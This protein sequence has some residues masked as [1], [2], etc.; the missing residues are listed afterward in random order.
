M[1]RSPTVENTSRVRNEQTNSDIQCS[2]CKV[3][4]N[5][6]LAFTSNK[7]DTL[8]E[9]AIIQICLSTYSCDEIE[10]A[11]SIAL[12]LLAPSKK[13]MRR[14]EG[15][16]QKSIQDIIKMIKEF[17]PDCLPSFVA[18]NLNKIP[19]VS[20]DYIDVTAFLKEMA[21]LRKDVASIKA[22]KNDS[23]SSHETAAIDCLKV[24]LAEVKKMLVELSTEQKS[25]KQLFSTKKHRE[26]SETLTT[27]GPA[28]P[29]STT[30]DSLLCLPSSSQKKVNIPTAA[31]DSS[32]V[33]LKCT[34]KERSS[35]PPPT[36]TRPPRAPSATQYRDIVLSANASKSSECPHD[37]NKDD[38]FI[39]VERKQR[40]RLSNFCGTGRGSGILQVATLTS[41][42]YVSR[43]NKT[44]SIN[45]LHE[46]IKEMGHECTSIELLPQKQETEF[47][48]FKLVVPRLNIDTF[49]N[50]DFWPQ[51]VKFRRYREY[52]TP[53]GRMD[54][55]NQYV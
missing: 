40:K 6:L 41:A 26:Q 21:L 35:G 7:V 25:C 23:Q 27:R 10:T 13:F 54:K 39:L 52:I 38:G 42:I 37:K 11:R 36:G 1:V 47:A 51:G 55:N 53:K 8:P 43:L 16:E 3:V 50:E 24:E 5:E 4:V 49:L 15:S 2:G 34:E 19:P 12:K 31:S 18:K 33:H 22:N 30:N 44:T 32:A 14:K 48:S 9:P 17:E 29:A 45:N 46:Y 28:D 20:F